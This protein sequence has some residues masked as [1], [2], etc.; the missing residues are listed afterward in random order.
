MKIKRVPNGCYRFMMLRG[1]LLAFVMLMLK[2]DFSNAASYDRQDLLDR[3]LSLALKDVTL[4]S[5]LDRIE[6]S[7]D[8]TFM[9]NN[10]DVDEG[11]VISI[12]QRNKSLRSILQELLAPL[13]LEFKVVGTSILIQKG[14][15]GR[16]T[17][18]T[19]GQ[20]RGRV[21][22]QETGEALVGANIIV[23]GS[24]TGTSADS[25]GYYEI[26]VPSERSVLA[27]SYIGYVTYEV[28][29]GNQTII[30]VA[31]V[32]DVR[33]INEVVV[34]GYGTQLKREV[35][36]SVGSLLTSD[37]NVAYQPIT[38][39]EQ[40]M[41]GRIPGV[42]VLS[43]S[44]SPGT[45][46]NVRVRGTTS[47]NASNDPLYVVDGVP[48]NVGNYS[49]VAENAFGIN[50]LSNLSPNDIESI[51]VLKDAS[52]S[53]IYGSRASNGVI[54][55]TTK[56]GKANQQSIQFNTYYGWQ[57]A[58]RR[59]PLLESPEYAT[60]IN[61]S[62]MNG[63]V[64]EYFTNPNSLPTTDW[65]EEVFRTA[66]ISNYDLSASGG[67]DRIRYFV[68]GGYLNQEGIII[69]SGFKKYNL[70]INLNAESSERFR[71]GVNFGATRTITNRI[72]AGSAGVL[73]TA[74][75]KAP[76]LPVY[77]SDGTY[78]TRDTLNPGFDNPVALARI[79]KH[80]ATNNRLIGNVYAEYDLLKNLTFRTSA[81]I[82][83]LS[84]VDNFT[85]DRNK[86]TITGRL[87]TTTQAFT[88]D[89][90]WLTENTL[91]Y[92][93]GD[94]G[95][96][97]FELLAG[98][99]LQESGFQRIVARSEN[100]PVEGI[101]TINNGASRNAF[102]DRT[103]WGLASYFFR[104]NYSLMDR[105][106]LSASY[107]IDGSSRFAT[108]RMY[109]QFPAVS[110]GWIVSEEGFM[111]EASFVDELKVRASWGVT[112]N[113]NIGNFTSRGLSA[114]GA[115][116]LG[117]SGIAP[118][119]LENPDLTW[120]TTR[121]TNLGFEIRL[122]KT[123]AFRADAYIKKTEGLLLE[124]E[125]PQSSGFSTSMKN[126]GDMEN[127]GIELQLDYS[128]LAKRSIR[129]T[130]SI[131]VSFNRNK[132][133]NLPTG[134]KLLGFFGFASILRE[135]YPIGSFY[136][137]KIQGVDPATGNYIFQDVNGDDNAPLPTD[138]DRVILGSPHPD[139]FGGFSNNIMFK[140]FEINAF[141]QFVYGNEIFNGSK[142]Y[143]QAMS[144]F[145]NADVG[146]RNR[147]REAGDHS[148][149]HRAVWSDP[150]R[151]AFISDRPIED[152]SYLRLKSLT[153][154]Y[155]I[156]AETLQ[157][158]NIR[159]LKVYFTGQNLFTRTRYSGFDPEV[160]EYENDLTL[161]FDRN[162]YPQARTFIVGFSVG[163]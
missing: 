41:Q 117:Q 102:G 10:G 65:Q 54:L 120:E 50:V 156:P 160:N 32:S 129:W 115:D 82:D 112:G 46:V 72:K 149:L 38:T 77:N 19:T 13:G 21:I 145:D 75:R 37:A 45:S 153:L 108:N 114:G 3:K 2:A 9:Y 43:N 73:G 59:L 17:K 60:L 124:V 49:G 91:T 79:P 26:S 99:S 12:N 89:F 118:V 121:Q 146:V 90:S 27:F 137:W 116:Y 126:I 88:E 33:R 18:S 123:L 128:P 93:Y 56:K 125:I 34:V 81:G 141:I 80:S 22:D 66:P 136:G 52:A 95:I 96:H 70:R 110:I 159:S 58:W 134:D 152:G 122:L 20:V 148:T 109:G 87:G 144:N 132:V 103:S 24:L 92:R 161:G 155:N 39:S 51:E 7:V 68:S 61:E 162:T 14:L 8:V 127:K 111:R 64:G 104:A 133:T 71:Y 139:F 158:L 63:G 147:W 94:G 1:V 30:D 42:N 143:N 76:T 55:I 31:L 36:G 150:K 131:N 84:L 135:G 83:H 5:A 163:L 15:S 23:K 106:L 107:R 6:L 142:Y 16:E 98:F 11:K 48:V 67:S 25:D 113:Q 4:R 157:R 78:F 140:N 130:S 57:N 44:G 86:Y 100:F 28:V 47:I 85:I 69:G 119:Q 29:V 62:R 40:I 101:S 105:Y 151:N 154:G 35:T 74:V 53:S 138:P 97:N